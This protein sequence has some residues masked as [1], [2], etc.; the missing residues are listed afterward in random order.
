MIKVTV[1]YPKRVGSYFDHNYYL[2]VHIPLSIRLLGSALQ[3]VSVERGLAPGAPWPDPS[4]FAIA[5]FVC[6]T[7]EAYTQELGP[8]I[9]RLQDDVANFTNVE[10]VVQIGEVVDF[11]LSLSAPQLS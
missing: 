3:S 9:K 10:P 2:N 6:E 11:D 7:V 1:L 5:G 8:H 4:F